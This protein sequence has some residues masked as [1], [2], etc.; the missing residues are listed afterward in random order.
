MTARRARLSLRGALNG[1]QDRPKQ[2]GLQRGDLVIDADPSGAQ[3]GQVQ[4]QAPM[5]SSNSSVTSTFVSVRSDGDAETAASIVYHDELK[6]F[7]TRDREHLDG[8]GHDQDEQ[9]VHP[10]TKSQSASCTRT[11]TTFWKDCEV[12]HY[13]NLAHLSSISLKWIV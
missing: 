6:M 10:H 12:P 2:S 8:N 3:E 7:V 4:G 9:P 5:R 13:L 1:L 11:Q